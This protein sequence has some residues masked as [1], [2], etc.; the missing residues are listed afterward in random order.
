MRLERERGTHCI[1]VT[2]SHI[3]WGAKTTKCDNCSIIL[4]TCDVPSHLFGICLDKCCFQ[5]RLGIY[6]HIVEI[7]ETWEI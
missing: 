4:E 1:N 7:M 5:F 2:M 6:F 3:F